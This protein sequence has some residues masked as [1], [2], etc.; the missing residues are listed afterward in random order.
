MEEK[1]ELD[2]FISKAKDTAIN[3]QNDYENVIGLRRQLKEYKARLDK[4]YLPMK[5]KTHEAWK[6]VCD[7]INDYDKPIAEADKKLKLSM[8]DYTT[9]QERERRAEEDRIRREAEEKEKA[10]IEEELKE[11]G[12]KEEEAKQ[13][14]EKIDLYV[15]EVKIEDKTKVEGVSY[16]TNYKYRIADVSKIPVAYMMPDEKKIGGV[17]RAMK[18]N[19]NIPGIE[20]YTEKTPIDRY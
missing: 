17:V 16:R 3:N 14:A 5:K 10:R 19:T 4:R 6:E 7:R 2:L 15:P 12:Y 11:V 13:E 8:S 1:N 20:I 18:E 9:R